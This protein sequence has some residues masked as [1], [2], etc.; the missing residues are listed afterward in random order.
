MDSQF[1]IMLTK[2]HGCQFDTLKILILWER[3]SFFKFLVTVV[4]LTVSFIL[5]RSFAPN[6]GVRYDDK[7][8][9]LFWLAI[10]IFQ[11]FQYLVGFV[12]R[13]CE[14]RDIQDNIISTSDLF[15]EVFWFWDV[16]Y[17]HGIRWRRC[18]HTSCKIWIN[19]PDKSMG[20]FTLFNA[21]V[22]ISHLFEKTVAK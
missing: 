2:S 4:W 15:H 11:S 13:A 10:G 16:N 8:L 19:C 12:Q 1:I 21:N 9:F 20:V 17:L 18:R 5:W 6:H 22:I 14:L 3:D 7:D